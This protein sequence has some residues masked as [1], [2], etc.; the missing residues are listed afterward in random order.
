[1]GPIIV[2]NFAVGMETPPLGY[3]LFVGSAISG[4]SVEEIAK[5]MFPFFLV[6]FSMLLLVTYVPFFTLFLPTLVFG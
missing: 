4:L 1:L 2:I 6:D 3:S 5:G